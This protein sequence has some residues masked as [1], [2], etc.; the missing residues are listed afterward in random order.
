MFSPA[1]GVVALVIPEVSEGFFGVETDAWSGPCFDLACERQ[2]DG[3][4][5]V[6]T[7]SPDGTYLIFGFEL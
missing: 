5:F 4:G 6:G 3:V 1:I 2:G 7:L